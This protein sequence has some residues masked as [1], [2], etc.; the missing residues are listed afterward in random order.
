MPD[1]LHALLSFNPEKKMSTVIGSWKS[2]LTRNRG[3]K[4]QTNYFDHRIRN[5]AELTIKYQYILNNPV[6]KGLCK[7]VETWPW[8]LENREL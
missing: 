3:I 2:Y 5:E 1:H 8:K 4:W 6:A 7:E